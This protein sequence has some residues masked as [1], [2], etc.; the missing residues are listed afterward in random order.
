MIE[1]YRF[2][3]IIIDGKEYS[4]D[5]IIY[6]DHVNSHWWRREGHRLV[7]EDIP[8]IIKQKPEILVVGTG[9]PGL[10]KVPPPTAQYIKAKGI[11]LI[12]EKTRKAWRTY[13]DLSKSSRVIAVFH[14]TC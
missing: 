1:S 10:M 13:N 9:E 7:P 6:P 12:V 5:V 11:R 3:L 4:S 14:L 2:G 8:E